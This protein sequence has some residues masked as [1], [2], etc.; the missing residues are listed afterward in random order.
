MLSQSNPPL[1]LLIKRLWRHISPRRR[2]QFVCLSGLTALSSFFE[3]VSLGAVIP[4]VGILTQPEKIFNLPSMG[5]VA[6][7]L[8]ISSAIDLILPITIAFAMAALVAGAIRLLLLWVSTKFIYGCGA[9]LSI[10]VFSRT[11]YQPYSVHVGRNSSTVISGIAKIGSAQ[12]TLQALVS[13]GISAAMIFSILVVLLFID[14]T[15]AMIAIIG[16]GFC[17]GLIAFSSRRRI[18]RNS[19][20]IALE[21]TQMVKVLQEGLGGIRDVLLGGSQPL[22]CNIYRNSQLPVMQALSSSHFFGTSP[23]YVMESFGMVLIAALAYGLSLR[24]GGFASAI[25]VLGALALG[26][27]RLLPAMQQGYGAWSSMA[28]NQASLADALKLLDQ[29][30]P[31]E[32]Y[33]PAPAPLSFQDAIRFDDVFFSYGTENQWVLNSFN[34]I[35]NKGSRVGFVG[36]TGSGK[37][38]TLDLLM[39]I[40]EP[41]Q[42]KILVDGHPISGKHLRAW[43]QTI[44]HV[45]QSIFLADSTLAENIAFGVPREA[46]NMDR[47]RKAASQ[48]QIACFIESRP[49]GY[50]SL[51]GERGILLSGGQRQR[52]GIARALYKS[53]SVLVF[54][55]ATSALDNATEQTVIDAIESLNRDLTIL[56]VAHR[57]T[58]VQH[59]DTIVEMEHGRVV[60]QGTFRQLLEDSASFRKLVNTLP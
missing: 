10:E 38:T 44:A 7:A 56:L 31:K 14:A 52:L 11:L 33:E 20:L 46:I 24:A 50:Q 30:M 1:T 42:G 17:Y 19:Q 32:A 34:L 40:L 28:A 49:E 25:P 58:T 54:D 9:D 27:Q 35:I 47:V 2:W 15:V 60:A 37:S 55:E 53:A 6:K 59:C 5:W 18:Q 36:S 48:A 12:A 21:S 8:G 4:F 26:A 29:P 57:L 43:Q 51:V 45:P 23:R 16:F 39:G 13:L 22:Y 3:V 41:V